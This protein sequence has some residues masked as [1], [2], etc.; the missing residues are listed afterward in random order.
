MFQSTP[1]VLSIQ[2]HVVHGY[3]GNKSAVFPLQV[4]GLEVD[5]INTVQFSTHTAYKHI[6]GTV[7]DNND[8]E[9][10]IS[11]LILNDVDYYT[12]FLTGYSRSP[13]SLKQIAQ[14]IKKLKEKSPNLVYVC[15]PVMGDNGQMYVPDSILPVYRDDVVPLADI[16][17]PNQFEA[18]CLTGLTM[19]DFNGAIR[20]IQALH[21]KGVKIVVLSSTVL[22]DE[23]YMIGIA[24]NGVKC[25][26]IQIPKVEASFTGTGDLF[27]ALFLAWTHKTEGD[28]KLTLENTIATLQTIVKNTYDYAR[29]IQPT[30]KL[31]PALIEL[32]LIQNKSVIEN[33]VVSITATEVCGCFSK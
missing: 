15:D 30:G 7:L 21:D 6:K 10:I 13:D 20:I 24:S 27:A 4:L 17:T 11:G 18:E 29:A 1:R 32:R 25:Y 23:D 26:Q 12:H 16:L 14:V 33:P 28:L 31:P 5:A 22:G 9:E 2:S 8:L 19:N 3:V